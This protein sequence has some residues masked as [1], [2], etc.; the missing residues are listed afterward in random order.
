MLIEIF[1][2]QFTYILSYIHVGC[3]FRQF[4]FC[5]MLSLK[6]AIQNGKQCGPGITEYSDISA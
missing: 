2:F 5:N 1:R 4:V 3:I 6:L